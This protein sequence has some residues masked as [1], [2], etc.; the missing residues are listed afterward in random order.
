[1]DALTIG[2]SDI[3]LMSLAAI[4]LLIVIGFSAT[5]FEA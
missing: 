3:G 4:V 5:S 2:G 1:M